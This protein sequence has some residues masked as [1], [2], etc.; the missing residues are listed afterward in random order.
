MTSTTYSI[1]G[2]G[3]P[4]NQKSYRWSEFAQFMRD[5]TGGDALSILISDIII[6]A[7]PDNEQAKN[8]YVF[9]APNGRWYR[10]ILVKHN[11]YGNK[12]RDFVINLIETLSKVKGGDEKTTTL[13]A[14]I[15]VGSRFRSLFIETGASYAVERLNKLSDDDLI[16]Q[17]KRMLQDIDRITA[18][19]ADDGLTDYK[20]LQVL[21]GDSVEVRNIFAAFEDVFPPFVG[22]IKEF[23]RVPVQTN[24]EALFTAY[25]AYLTAA[26]KNN[27]KFLKLC[28]NEYSKSLA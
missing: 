8:D 4:A 6:S 13:V 3:A 1:F 19:A 2:A 25:Q 14:G 17:S 15:V 23:I 11:V 9:R 12:R 26:R 20:A 5:K 10:V 22:A 16:D 24:R 18:D 7:L 27:S 28:I 21:L